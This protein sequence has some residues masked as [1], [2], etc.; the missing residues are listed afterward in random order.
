MELRNHPKMKWQGRPNWPPQWTGPYGPDNP[1]PEGEVGV[2]TR[3]EIANPEFKPPH[4]FLEMQY[5]NQDYFES[6]FFDDEKFLQK[7]CN[8][9]NAYIGEPIS[10]IGSLDIPED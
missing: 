1:L 10:A 2:L 3:V 5:N 7:L 4:C 9:L 6:L 8:I